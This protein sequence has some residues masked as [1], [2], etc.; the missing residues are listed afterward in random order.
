MLNKL[1]N[2]LKNI[3]GDKKS[4]LALVGGTTIAQALNFLFSPIQ[5]RLFS[6]EVFGELAVFTSITSI[7]G[8]IICLGYDQGI[9]LP[10]EDDE[11][12]AILKVSWLFALIISLLSMFLLFVF[13]NKIYYNFGASNLSYYWFYVPLLLLTQ[14]F[15]QS[16][17]YWLIRN[18]KFKIISY[19]KVIP[20][21]F[22]NILSI[23]LG[24][25]GFLNLGARLFAILIG[26]IINVAILLFSIIDDIKKSWEKISRR[27]II[28]KY[29]NFL[30]YDI[31]SNLINTLSWMIIPV[32]L[33]MY[34][35]SY[36]A[37]QYSIGLKII[38]LPISIIGASFGQ[39]F[40]KNASEKYH[41]NE[42]YSYT[43]K[44][45]KKLF[46][47]TFPFGLI[48]LFFGREL[49]VFVFGEK[50]INAGLYVQIL[51]PWAVFWF[52]SSPIS[53]I[54][55]IVQKQYISLITSCL[56]LLFR[57]LAIYIA[58]LFKNDL[59]AMLLLSISGIIV[60]GL[61]I[62]LSVKYSKYIYVKA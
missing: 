25:I 15:I 22:V 27:N 47:Y 43:K 5:T 13:G 8:T 33:N 28:F 7:I 26:N 49:F 34:F 12:Y 45:I 55:I 24:F 62:F 10:K 18:K 9:P 11:G 35:D 58:F 2:R 32:L 23:F 59:L 20:T 56:N 38:Q 40:F 51:S 53:I 60:S 39:V 17:N 57:F 50:W 30:L 16:T 37:G 29:K 46:L 48:L 52:V 61:S 19:N 44:Y 21:L 54:Y 14:G 36:V 4:V 41:N 31:W 6:P 3:S 1:S 42:L